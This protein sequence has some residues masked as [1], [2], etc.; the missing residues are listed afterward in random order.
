MASSSLTPLKPTSL[1][2]TNPQTLRPQP[3]I[4][5]GPRDNRGPLHKGRVLSS[6]AIQAIQALKRTNSKSN[7]NDLDHVASKTLT[8]LVKADL[9]AAFHELLRQDQC[10]LALRVF[11]AVRSEI[12]YRPD[13]NLYA[14]IVA[15]LARNGRAAEIDGVVAELEREG[16]GQGGGISRLIRG[17]VGTGR[18]EAVVRVYGV[19]RRESVG[20]DEYVAKVLSRGLRRLGEEGV[21]GQVEREFLESYEGVVGR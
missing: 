19:M 13:C 15:A 17:L 14:E 7:N 11:S 5:C 3:T 20:V 18:R 6:E 2:F 9:L 21:A 16:V 4:R 8:R 1:I 10:D 12:W